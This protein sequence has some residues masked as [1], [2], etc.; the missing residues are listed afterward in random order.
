MWAKARPSLKSPRGTASTKASAGGSAAE[1]ASASQAASSTA[2]NKTAKRRMVRPSPARNGKICAQEPL[3]GQPHQPGK[4]LRKAAPGQPPPRIVYHAKAGIF[5]V[6]AAF[7][8]FFPKN[9]QQF[10]TV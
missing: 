10:C 5:Y 8:R 7:F 6:C 2:A 1:G 4:S 3:P 9:R